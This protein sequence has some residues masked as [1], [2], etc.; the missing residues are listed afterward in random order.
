MMEENGQDP[1]RDQ[2]TWDAQM[3]PVYRNHCHCDEN[4][5]EVVGR[6]FLL[7]LTTVD[8]IRPTAA[9]ATPFNAAVT[10]A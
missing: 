6:E 3:Q 9:A 1:D 7:R 4:E 2:R 8:R 5:V 10:K